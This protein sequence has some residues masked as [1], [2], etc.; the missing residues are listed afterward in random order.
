MTPL[1]PARGVRG[2]PRADKVLDV[3]ELP[4]RPL[5]DGF[6][7]AATPSPAV[8]EPPTSRVNRVGMDGPP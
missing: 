2:G 6:P 7:T 8:S 1:P 3:R 5:P 4:R